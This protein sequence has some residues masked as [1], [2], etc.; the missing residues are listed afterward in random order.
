MN[1]INFQEFTTLPHALSLELNDTSTSTQAERSTLATSTF[2]IIQ[3]F[4]QPTYCPSYNNTTRSQPSSSVNVPF[5]SLHLYYGTVY[6]IPLKIQHLFHHL[7]LVS[8][9]SCFGILFLT[10]FKKNCIYLIS[11]QIKNIYF[12]YFTY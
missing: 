10:Y 3:V 4:V 12:I 9:H 8:K 1:W 7:K 6:R 5:L 2:T 11:H